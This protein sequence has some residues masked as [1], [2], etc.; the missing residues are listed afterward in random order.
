MNVFIGDPLLVLAESSQDLSGD[1]DADGIPDERDN[2]LDVSNPA[3]R[4]SNHDQ[5]GNRCNPDVDNDG[6]VDTSW[7]QIYPRDARGDLEAIAL[8]ARNGPYDPDHDLDGDGPPTLGRRDLDLE[9]LES[10]RVPTNRVLEVHDVVQELGL[11]AEHR[12]EL[13]PA[14]VCRTR[15][16]VS[17]VSRFSFPGQGH[18]AG[19]GAGG[20]IHPGS[21]SISRLHSHRA[22]TLHP[23]GGGP[24]WGT[25]LPPSCIKCRGISISKRT[26]APAFH[27]TTRFVDRSSRRPL[28]SKILR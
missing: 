22:G 12:P 3:Q 26:I 25:R 28:G 20:R 18:R 19:S 24:M 16:D 13:C 27:R 21:R 7:G 1:L 15:L 5:I 2:C 9:R 8:T 10:C 17:P 6:R 4:D 14:P 23:G 11:E